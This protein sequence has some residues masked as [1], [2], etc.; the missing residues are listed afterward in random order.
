MTTLF[1]K[2]NVSKFVLVGPLTPEFS[3]DNIFITLDKGLDL[4]RETVS[5]SEN[6]LPPSSSHTLHFFKD[7][8]VSLNVASLPPY[9]DEGS[10]ILSL[11]TDQGLLLLP[12]SFR[13]GRPYSNFMLV[14][15][16]LMR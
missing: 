1:K 3:I 5:I 6:R 8:T 12:C 4:R 9:F 15:G 11:W 7:S 14:L 10:L 2:L 16:V 13:R